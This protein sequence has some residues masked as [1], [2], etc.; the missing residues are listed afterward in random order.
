MST[1]GDDCWKWKP[2]LD[3]FPVHSQG[4]SRT[5]LW[6]WRS[7]SLRPLLVQPLTSSSLLTTSR[8]KARPNSA[9]TTTCTA[10]CPCGREQKKQGY[11][12]ADRCNRAVFL[13]DIRI[14]FVR[15][16]ETY[17][18]MIFFTAHLFELYN[19]RFVLTAWLKLRAAQTGGF[20]SIPSITRGIHV[21]RS[22][23]RRLVL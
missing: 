23:G 15:N 20:E 8:C 18:Y 13:S 11:R 9:T 14:A 2:T 5:R 22:L 19:S 12:I 17:W 10:A 1:S 21:A 4:R 6:L 7:P 16:K 3:S